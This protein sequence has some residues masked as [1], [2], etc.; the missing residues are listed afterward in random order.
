MRLKKLVFFFFLILCSKLILAQT[1]GCGA[2]STLLTP[3]AAGA[4]CSAIAG[5]TSTGFTDSNLGCVAGTEDDDGWYRFVATATSHTI[6]VDG[7]A[8]FDAVLGIYN[9][10]GGA[11]PTGGTCVDATSG[12]GIET[13]TVT[14]LSIGTTY[15]ICVH[16]WEVGGGD[17]TICITTPPAPPSNDGCG[18]PTSLTPGA[19]GA[20]CSATAG[21]S[22]NATLSGQGCT[23]GNEDDDVWYSFVATATS[24]TVL[25]NGAANMDAVL[26]VYST[27]A[28]AQPTG[29]ACV[30][31]TGSDGNE[32]VTV[33]GLTIGA[34]YLICIYDFAAGSG[35]FTV[36]VTTPSTPPANDGCGTPT[37]LTPGAAGAACS[38]T[39]GSSLT[40]TFSGQGCTTGNEDD[41]VWY[42]FVATA[43]S[44]TVLVNGAANMDAVLGVYTT[45]AGAQP[46]GGT[47]VDASGAD[48][49]ETVTVTGLTIGA[50]YLICIY[51][52]DAGGGDF[53][54][55]ITTPVAGPA[56]DDCSGGFT[57]ACG[58]TYSGS[59]AAATSASDPSALCG[60][61][62]D[63]N[64]VWYVFAGDGNSITASLCGS[65]Y[66]T[67]INVYSGSCAALTCIG[68]NDDFCGANSQITFTSTLG[69]NYYILVNGYAAESGNYSLS[70]TC[71]TPP[72]A[73]AQDCSGGTTICANTSFSGNSSGGGTFSDFTDTNTDCL[74][75]P[76]HQTSW[77]YFSSTTNG[78]IGMTITPNLNTDDYDWAIWGP[79][80]AVTCPPNS[81]P[82]RCSAADGNG[83]AANITGLGNGATDVSEGP[84]GDGWVSLLNVLAGEVYV[85]VLDNWT[86]SNS[87]FTLS[88][89]LTNGAN[90]NCAPLPVELI[91]FSGKNEGIK[92]RIDWSTVS[93]TNNAFFTVERSHTGNSFESFIVKGGAGNSSIQNDYY[94]YDHSPFNGTT[95]YRLK[96]TDYDGK[97]TYSSTIAIQNRLNEITVRNVHPNPT[98]EDLN[99]E[100]YSPVNGTVK[101]EVLDLTGRIVFDKIQ[102]VDEGKS[103]LNTQIAGLA[104]GVYSL[105]VEFSEANFKFITKIVKY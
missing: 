97:F 34:T 98:T 57:A 44:H 92:N 75:T 70:I 88:W 47:C 42:S 7:A 14:G 31:A 25:V 51:D 105:K 39:S 3:G 50:T 96:Q 77:Y 55:C 43:T 17:F 18:S 91:S 33:T 20:A 11:Q 80:N 29:G 99:F 36:C 62:P 56:N 102:N 6:T 66:D 83:T 87:P 54:V 38:P 82:V 85:M 41:D 24:H 68:G 67:Q 52:Y 4:A 49:N 76:E 61:D 30:D 89:Q 32:T 74:D 19:P 79:M 59:T 46:T 73:T 8:N 72:A 16:D 53:T 45:C 37:S 28:G 65:S 21:S 40:A 90:L 95:Y 35:D 94:V 9:S 86:A 100:F 10:C 48:G 22:L 93:E 13:C 1:D 23:T 104:K 2:S 81:A 84:Y 78:T 63:G 15:Y 60:A 5:S 12:N 103:N 26:G 69:V 71:A 64:G 58:G 101:I 27:C